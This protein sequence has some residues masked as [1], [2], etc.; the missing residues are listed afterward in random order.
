MNQNQGMNIVKI[1]DKMIENLTRGR[2]ILMDS[3]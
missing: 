3:L 1:V 2:W